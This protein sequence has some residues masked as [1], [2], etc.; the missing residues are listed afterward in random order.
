MSETKTPPPRAL[1][2]TERRAH[3]AYE[4]DCTHRSIKPSDSDRNEFVRQ[5]VQ[6]ETEDRQAAIEEW[7]RRDPHRFQP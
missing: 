6:C 1:T 5:W 7:H 3:A 2:V 4:Q